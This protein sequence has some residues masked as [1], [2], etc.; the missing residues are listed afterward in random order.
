MRHQPSVTDAATTPLD[1]RPE[2][3][4]VAWCLVVVGLISL[5]GRFPRTTWP[6]QL[7]LVAG[8]LGF[9]VAGAWWVGLP[10]VVA[11]RLVWLIRALSYRISPGSSKT[12]PA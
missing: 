3:I 1:R 10:V 12:H 8:L 6:E 4:A 5:H 2:V 9:I 11:A 7:G